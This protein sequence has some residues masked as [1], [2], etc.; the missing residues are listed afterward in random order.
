[1]TVVDENRKNLPAT[2]RESE[3]SKALGAATGHALD[4]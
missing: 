3:K 4:E 2:E 1:M